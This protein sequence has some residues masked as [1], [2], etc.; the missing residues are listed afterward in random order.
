[1]AARVVGVDFGRDMIRAVE[2][3]N[4][5]KARP[6]IVKY[7]EMPLPG[8]AVRS[9][10]VREVDTVTTAMK[11]LW[12]TGGFS[13]KNVVLGIANQRVLVR[14][15]S[16]PK[17][18]L[19]QIKESL[20]FQVQDMLPVPAADA[21][22]DFYPFSEAVGEHGAVIN[23][24]LIAAIKETV[25]TNVRSVRQAGLRVVDVDLIP[26]ALTRV[27]VRGALAEGTAVIIDVGANTTNIVVTVDALPVLVRM[28]PFGG[29]TITDALGTR[30]GISE[31]DADV[32]KRRRGLA[33]DP[34]A[35]EIESASVDIIRGSTLELLNAIRNTLQFFASTR[36][37]DVLRNIVLTGG[38]AQLG[39]FTDALAEMTRLTVVPASP[40][41]TVEVSKSL[42]STTDPQGMTVA[43]GLALGSAA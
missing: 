36:P 40:L 13:S 17:M 6:V 39:G 10:E 33:N 41:S 12:A 20:P 3:E 30:L 29:Q 28:I 32:L 1:M 42:G 24:L 22:L 31:H 38:G 35:S 25:Q 43:L 19:V 16:V 18:S 11:R 8:G 7:H 5:D 15:L 21:L 23:G 27:L 9:G 34:T 37:G 26:F 4:A 14:E 2:V